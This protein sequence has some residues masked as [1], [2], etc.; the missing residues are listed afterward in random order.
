M[1]YRKKY[2][3]NRIYISLK[4]KKYVEKQYDRLRHINNI[5]NKNPKTNIKLLKAQK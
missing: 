3:L 1:Y 2:F 4:P 5:T